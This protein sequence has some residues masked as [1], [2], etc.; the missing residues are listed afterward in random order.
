MTTQGDRI[1][2]VTLN[3]IGGKGLFVK[4]LEQALEDGRADLAV[5]SLKDVPMT[6]PEGF[7]LAAIG[8]REDPRDA[9]VSNLY[10]HLSELPPGA[11]VGTSSLR[12]E[13]QLRARYPHLRVE[14]LRGNVNTR[15]RKLDEGQYAAIIL[16]AA[17]L[18]RLGFAGRITAVL[19]PEQSLPAA[20]QGALGIEIRSGR[21]DLASLLVNVLHVPGNAAVESRAF[22]AQATLPS[23]QAMAAWVGLTLPATPLNLAFALALAAALGVWVLLWHTKL[24]LALRTTGMAP[25]A[26]HYAGHD[27]KRLTVIALGIS[28][29]LAGLAGVNEIAGVHHKLLLDFIAGAGFI[30]IAV[31]LMGRSHPLGIVIASLL[32]GALAQGGSEL[33][34]EMP[35]FTRDM[36][37]AVQGLVVLF[38]GALG[39]M[40]RPLVVRLVSLLQPGARHG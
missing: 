18:K 31:A 30:G 11:V 14:P 2:D 22:A 29:A 27:P 5:H 9:F 32:F 19:E 4:E 36:S 24:G 38:C 7:E 39:L 6:L 28:G 17:G 12:R 35:V 40:A 21:P 16:A 34:F 26:A 15:L 23:A 25:E 10:K 20:G 3:K 8:E 13:S 33:V 1:L 37:V